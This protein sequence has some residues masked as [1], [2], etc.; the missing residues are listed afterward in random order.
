MD[1]EHFLGLCGR[2]LFSEEYR[3]DLDAAWEYL[4]QGG[5]DALDQ[6]NDPNNNAEYLRCVSIFSVLTGNLAEAFRHLESLHELLPRLPQEWGVRYTNYKLLA[7]YTR[8]FPPALR[9]YHE[10][11][12]PLNLMML[13]DIIGPNEMDQNTMANIHKYWSVGTLRDRALLQVLRAVQWHPTKARY[14]SAHY[15]PLSPGGTNYKPDTAPGPMITEAS[16]HMVRCRDIAEANGA[17]VIAVHLT[18]LLAE[19]HITSQSPETVQVLQDLYKRCEKLNDYAGMA[20][21]K[22]MEG[23]NI[24]CPP[25]ASP[26]SLNLVIVD[27][28]SS[29]GD[30]SIWDPI[31]FDLKFDYTAESMQCYE[32]ALELFQKGNCKRGQAAV[33][34]RQG[35]CLHNVARLHRSTNKQYLDALGESETKLQEALEL[36]GRDE[37]NTQIVKTHQ[38]LVSIAKGNLNRVK[39]AAREI[40]NW[41]V[42]AKNELLAHFL[43]LLL[44]RFAHQ[45]WLMFSNMD[46]ALAAWECAYEVLDSVEDMIPLFQS[47]VS[48]AAVQHEM[49]NSLA[50]GILIEEAL[51]MFDRLRNYLNTRIQSAPDTPLGQADKI[52]LTTTK[53]TLLWTFGRHVSRIYMRAEDLNKFNEW[54]VKQAHVFE[55]DDSFREYQERLQ[56]SANLTAVFK[57]GISFPANKAKDL[58]RKTLAD[59]AVNVRFASAEIGYRR[60]LEDGD[61]LEA[62]E[63]F[64]RFV[65][66]AEQLEQV[67]TKDLYR[68]LACE[69]IGDQRKAREILDSITDNELFN[70]TLDDYQQGIAV[71][72]SFPTVAQNALIFTLFGGDLDRGRRLIDIITKISPTFFTSIVD[73][74]LDFSVRLG[75]Y[76]AIMKDLHPELCFSKLLHAR[77]IIELRR[78]QTNDQDARVG[79]S[80]TGWSREVYLNLARL[81]HTC[82][83]SAIPMHLLSDYDHGHF[84]GMSWA[85]HALLFVEMSRA[86]AVL[87]SL[88]TQAS[89]ASGLS[90][91]PKTAHLSEAVHKRRLL[92]TLLS[93]QSLTAEQEREVAQL[94]GDIKILEEDGALSS[95]TTF[96]ETVNSTIDPKRLYQSIDDNAVV[97]EAAFGSSGVVSFA[98]TREGIQNIHQAPTRNVDIRRPVMRAMKIMREMTGYAGEEEENHKIMLNGLSKE[99]SDILLVPFASIIRAKSHIIFSISDPLTAFP[100]SILPFDNQPLIMHAAVSQVPSLTV[101][102]Y[103]SQRKSPSKLPTVSVLAKSPTEA[104]YSATR[105]DT[106]VNLHMAAIEAVNIARLFATWP[107]EA[108]EITRKEFRQYVEGESLIMH[109]GTHGDINYRNPLLS[110]IS[111]GQGQDFR[112]VDMSTIRSNVNLLVFAACLSGF[113]RA[114]IGSEV[115]GFS[116]VVLSTGCQAYIG[117]LWKVSDFGSM[118]IMTLFYQHLKRQPHLSVAEIMKA[119]QMD[120]LQLDTNKAGALLDSMVKSW[121]P[122]EG[123]EQSPAQF[124]PDAEF[125][126]QTLK[127][128]L[129]QLDWSS[130]FYWAPFTLVGYGGFHFVHERA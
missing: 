113:G 53:C 129:D 95:A 67:Y 36:F 81:C 85:E 89:Q 74:A 50:A 13:S 123:N 103:L 45:E 9:F 35:C 91:A 128:I 78:K 97:I 75:H 69:R 6:N 7:D 79:S 101:L 8:R 126:F 21:S 56:Q 28:G 10:R 120:L 41:C 54:Q 77:Q 118:L 43:G 84:D 83:E 52:C 14:M 19:L 130:P 125:L 44:S 49:F 111:I 68:I 2:S 121:A 60:L 4:Q 102:Y 90:G 124:V 93:L 59:E 122:S 40:G 63:T 92:R 55:T 112:V 24:L 23:D 115:L 73:N 82:Q 17:Q 11:G 58:W 12:K 86:R 87:E 47:V 22:L 117:S 16:Q 110:S 127:M 62:E 3:G 80:P 98:V 104:P 64:R 61:V 116:H 27:T 34:L 31:E 70:G 29:I 51:G 32:S 33:L 20:N 39:T 96:I 108:S 106:E 38:I 1:F 15:H 5:S 107:I 26:L 119:A 88:Q 65:N 105:G 25:F 30:D 18:R 100:F 109:I 72:T 42:S 76:G 71:R 99:I 57:P 114:T 66:D 37:A 46:T 94:Q 48:R